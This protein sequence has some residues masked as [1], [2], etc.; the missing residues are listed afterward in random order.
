MKEYFT[1]AIVLNVSLIDDYDYLVE[2][3]TKEFGFLKARVLSGRKILSKLSPHLDVLNLVELRL[4]EKKQIIVADALLKD[5]FSNLR[6]NYSIL[7]NFLNLIFFFR[8]LVLFSQKDLKLWYWLIKTLKNQKIDYKEFLKI[9][10]YDFKLAK[11]YLCSRKYVSYF[12]II[13]QVFLC[14]DCAGKFRK[15]ELIYIS[16]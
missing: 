4:V 13:D 8:K 11:C 12:Y 10:G 9:L 14:Y 6:E 7:E 5:R 3:F 1:E 15:N 16:R 2:F